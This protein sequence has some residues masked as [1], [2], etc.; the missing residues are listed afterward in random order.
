MCKLWCAVAKHSSLWS[1]VDLSFPKVKQLESELESLCQERL[2]KTKELIL[3]GW[4]RQL[5]MNGIMAISEHCPNLT[6]INLSDCT[7]VNL[8][9]I[10]L[11]MD[12][13][14]KITSID[15]S[16]IAPSGGADSVIC[17]ESIG[18]IM[19]KCGDKLTHLNL[20]GNSMNDMH[21]LQANEDW[22]PSLKSLNLSGCTKL[23]ENTMRVLADKCPSLDTIDLS[24]TSNGGANNPCSCNSLRYV[25]SKCGSSI[26]YLN[27]ANNI[28][29]TFSGIF[30]ILANSCHNLQVLD[31]SNVSNIDRSVISIPIEKLQERCPKLRVFRLTNVRTLLSNTPLATQAVST[32]FPDLEELSLAVINQEYHHGLD[33]SS[34]QRIVKTSNKLKLLDVRGCTRITASGLVRFPAFD[35]EYLFLSQCVAAM[36][37]DIEIVMEKWCHSL[38]EVDLSWNNHSGDAV[39]AAVKSLAGCPSKSILHTLNLSGSAVSYEPVKAVLR[40]CPSLAVLDLSS[41]RGLPRGIK[42]LYKGED[43]Q[44]FKIEE[45]EA[46]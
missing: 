42:R 26:V 15:L 25:M 20:A 33:D 35:M 38:V 19:S 46:L 28:L 32:G 22:F 17:S 27:L 29:R 31:M 44:K 10:K 39:D 40:N 6:S 4:K 14:T 30:T 11:L 1:R 16:H 34:L 43:L 9:A 12:N 21:N 13:C 41:C 2:S 23:N 5:T 7:N 45:V 24:Y 3:S 8:K 36:T 18:Y 37:A